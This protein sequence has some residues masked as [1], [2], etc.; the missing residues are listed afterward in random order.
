LSFCSPFMRGEKMAQ[1]IDKYSE[2]LSHLPLMSWIYIQ[3]FSGVKGDEYCKKYLFKNDAH[4]NEEANRV[5]AIHIFRYMA[6]Q[7]NISYAGDG[8]ISEALKEYY[9]SVGNDQVDHPI[10]SNY[11][12]PAE[13]KSFIINKYLPL[14]RRY[15][16]E[17]LFCL[18]MY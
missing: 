16:D 9:Y 8:F 18:Q 2:S 1:V 11:S 10:P 12:I 7:L 13:R 4:W 17:D 3:C 14:E 15:I 5:A 6:D